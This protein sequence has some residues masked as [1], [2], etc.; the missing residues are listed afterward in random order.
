ME[1][2]RGLGREKSRWRRW[3]EYALGIVIEAAGV[4]AISLLALLMMLIIKAIMT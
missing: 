3:G 4:I 2:G 1:E